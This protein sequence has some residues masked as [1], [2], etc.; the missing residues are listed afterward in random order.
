[1]AAPLTAVGK[2]NNQGW[3]VHTGRDLSA[4]CLS[5]TVRKVVLK[6][7]RRVM[8]NCVRG[9]ACEI[10]P[11]IATDSSST[12]VIDDVIWAFQKLNK[13]FTISHNFTIFTTFLQL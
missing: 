9:A 3:R 5:T 4:A 11:G 7:D 10:P 12:I 8:G 13:I 6:I 1:M 2:N